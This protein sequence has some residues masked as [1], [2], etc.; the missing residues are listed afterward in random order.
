MFYFLRSYNDIDLF[1]YLEVIFTALELISLNSVV[2]FLFFFL[3]K[4]W[5]IA[6]KDDCFNIGVALFFYF[7]IKNNTCILLLL[8]LIKKFLSLFLCLVDLN[9]EMLDLMVNLLIEIL[10]V[11]FDDLVYFHFG[12]S[13]LSFFCSLLCLSWF[14][15]SFSL[16]VVFVKL[17]HFLINLY[18]FPDFLILKDL[19]RLLFCYNFLHVE[20]CFFF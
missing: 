1:F 10:R 7:L 12:F 8:W 9:P 6:E 17:M 5:G 4:S 16:V 20:I 19:I 3:S 11:E 18:Q 2:L 13:F 15:Y 14:G